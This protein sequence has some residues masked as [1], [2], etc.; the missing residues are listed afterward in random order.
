LLNA[1]SNNAYS[2]DLAVECKQLVLS[3]NIIMIWEE[4]AKV[5]EAYYKD[6]GGITF[7]TIY[8]AIDPKGKVQG[9]WENLG[10][11]SAWGFIK[12]G[13][14][15]PTQSNGGTMTLMLMANNYY[16]KT[17]PITAQDVTDTGFLN[18]MTTFEQ[19]VT[20]PLLSSA[21]LFANDVI[22]RGPAAYDFVVVYEALGI[23][24][25]KNAVGRHGQALRLIYPAFNLY[26]NHPLC[27]VNHPAITAQ[28]RD[29]ARKFQAFLLT[30]DIQKLA[31]TYGWRPADV[32]IPI[33]GANTPFDSTD[34]KAAGISTDVGQEI[35]VP[36]G[37][38]INQLLFAWQRATAQ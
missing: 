23:E 26:T 15:D 2:R 7:A 8:D 5:F 4:R 13:H 14:T 29:A 9:K 25:Y 31:L 34:L 36:S 22:A 24:Q 6:K 3:P 38:V 37:D 32:S 28:Q 17:S 20:K 27:L 35:Q 16:R 12:I 21:G 10:G 1:I 19:A 33:F 11:P 18:W 30:P